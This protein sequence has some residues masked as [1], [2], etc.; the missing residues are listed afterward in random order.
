MSKRRCALLIAVLLLSGGR[1]QAGIA[2]LLDGARKEGTVT[3]YTGHTDAEN[4]AAVGRAFTEKYPD[5]KIQ[6][7]RSTSEVAYQRLT[8]DLKLNIAQC[9]VFSS[10]D[11]AH[12]YHLKREKRLARYVPEN[13]ARLRPEYRGQDPDE[14]VYPTN[15]GLML[16]IHNTKKVPAAEAPKNWT[17]L[18]DPRWHGQ[19]SVGHPGFSGYVATWVVTMRKLY[20]WAYF[21]TFERN[22][23]LIGR[24]GNDPITILNAGERSVGIGP[25]G[26]TMKSADRGNPLGAIYPSDGALLMISPTA[27]LANA[28]HPNAARLFLEFLLDVEHDRIAVRDRWESLRPE[29][30]PAPGSVPLSSLKLIVPTVEDNVKGVPEVVERWRDLF[31]S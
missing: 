1:A 30:E 25:L 31:G 17:D 16:I 12:Y 2:D 21:E 11:I 14:M 18:L 10:T 22:K 29:V 4:A 13:A 3:W 9:D 15:A 5:V 28:P 19:L 6:V 23:P 24:S 26:T 7:V 20:G 27:I 8:Q